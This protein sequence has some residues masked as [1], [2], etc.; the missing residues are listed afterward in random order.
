VLAALQDDLVRTDDRPSSLAYYSR[1]VVDK[2]YGAVAEAAG[3]SAAKGLQALNKLINAHLHVAWQNT[4]SRGV[5][6]LKPHPNHTTK[7]VSEAMGLAE[8]LLAC[9]ETPMPGSCPPNRPKCTPCTSGSK[10]MK[11]ATIPYYRNSSNAFAIGVVP[12]PWTLA[13]LDLLR[14]TFDIADLKR[15][16]RRDPWLTEVTGELLDSSASGD[17]RV[18]C[19]KEAVASDYAEARALWLTAEDPLPMDLE[20]HFGF[21]IPKH[22]RHAAEKPLDRD[23]PSEDPA[24]EWILL[25]RAKQVIAQVRSTEDTKVR[26]SLE[27]WNPADTE[28]WKFARAFQARRAMERDQWE[29]EEAKYSQ[30]SGT[31]G[32]RSAWSRWQ[33]A[34]DDNG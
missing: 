2:K 22:P 6:V 26:A 27:E 33:D 1:Q 9:S 24:L 19:L 10:G 16:S 34:K 21:M 18:M 31:E 32:G 23:D 29:K 28:A 11:I 25:E 3:K 4:F 17:V 7:L 5:E 13:T 8:S 15:E 12:H 14:D 20:W 30:G